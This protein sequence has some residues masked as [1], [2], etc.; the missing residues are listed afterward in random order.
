LIPMLH[1]EEPSVRAAAAEALAAIGPAAEE[2]IEL[3]VEAA[4]RE[5]N[6]PLR[7]QA[8]CALGAVARRA[9][10]VVYVIP[11]LLHVLRST[12]EELQRAAIRSLGALG[13][14]AAVERLVELLTDVD[15]DTAE[16]AA[17]ALGAIGPDA[18]AAVPALLRMLRAGGYRPAGA[19]YA[20]G[21]IGKVDDA[22]VPAL[23]QALQ[24]PVP[25]VREEAAIALRAIAP[26]L[27]ANLPD[28][29]A[30]PP[31]EQRIRPQHAAGIAV[32]SARFTLGDY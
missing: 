27:V 22:I 13:T 17:L 23:L 16:E 21:R 1:D 29:H 30:T 11:H 4:M 15:G 9:D 19:A 12:K 31:E 5:D 20:L 25:D 6:K 3:L 10:Y 32:R 14:D 26:E 24:H 28:L 8:V 2:G 7:L 18:R